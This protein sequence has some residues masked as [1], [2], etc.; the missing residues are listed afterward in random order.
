MGVG[1]ELWAALS[2]L[3]R[4]LVDMDGILAGK[5][6]DLELDHPA[7]PDGLPIV[8]SILSGPGVLSHRMSPRVVGRLIDSWRRR[9]HPE[10]SGPARISFGVVKEI[11][12]NVELTVP[13]SDLCVSRLEDRVRD[14]IIGRIPGSRRG[15][16]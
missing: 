5:V 6:D 8:T 16:G 2:L 12:I 7:D 15:A 4:Q 11:G 3:D 13:R 1:R 14:R 10:Y 9:R